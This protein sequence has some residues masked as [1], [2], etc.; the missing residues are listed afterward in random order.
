MD[1]RD[2][3]NKR[4][5]KA[6]EFDEWLR[7]KE[8]KRSKPSNEGFSRR[9]GLKRTRLNP[10]S[11]K[12]KKK[13]VEYKHAR[14]EHYS[15]EE[16][17]KCHFCGKTENLSIHHMKK[18][19]DHLANQETFITLCL[20]GDFMDKRYPE[21]NHSHQGGCHAFIEANKSW[22]RKHGYL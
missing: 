10:V 3:S 15:K 14:E 1:E 12:Q 13:L 17:Q 16:N 8:E 6:Q 4:L 7:R 20:T 18:R 2:C 22:A 11:K 9:T 5:G 19:G 21:L